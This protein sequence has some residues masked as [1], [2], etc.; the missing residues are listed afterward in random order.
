MK[1]S[2]VDI[3]SM[4]GT[5]FSGVGAFSA[6][7]Y[8]MNVNRP[9][10]KATVSEIKYDEEGT[11]SIDVYNLKSVTAHISHIRLVKHS[12]STL[13][14]QSPS[15]FSKHPILI[16]TSRRQNERLDIEV[17]S[18]EYQRF[19]FS[20]KSILN[21]YCEI[22]DIK[23]PVGMQKMV[24]AQIAIYL[25]SGAVCYIPLPKSQYQKLKN[26]M[27][28]PIFRR[29][30]RLCSSNITEASPEKYAEEHNDKTYQLMLD[31]YENAMRRH[32]YLEL[33]SGI[34]MMH[35]WTNK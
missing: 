25:N 3:L 15:T 22:S 27:L 14:K 5:W 16:N 34:R 20:A 1:A 6:V 17:K 31:E 29:V 26:I 21:A 24:K 2:T 11:F 10:L 13:S 32:L 12:P 19:S 33:S 35:F 30:E 8:A 18:G 7:L 23:N 4:L 28:L 9:K